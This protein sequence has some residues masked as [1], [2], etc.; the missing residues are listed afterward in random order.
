MISLFNQIV[1]TLTA[2]GLGLV[3]CLLIYWMIVERKNVKPDP[4][5]PW[6]R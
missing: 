1:I 2:F 3:C 4:N 5:K 6:K